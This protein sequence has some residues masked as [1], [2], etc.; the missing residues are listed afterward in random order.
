VAAAVARARAGGGPT[1]VEA[2][3]YRLRGHYEGDPA[4][5]RQLSELGEWRAKD[6]IGRFAG[7]VTDAGLLGADDLAEIEAEAR[8]TVRA[9]ADAALAAPTPGADDIVRHVYAESAS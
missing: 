5:Y 1:F 7:E 9:A 6:P 4:K 3:T 2:L 8:T